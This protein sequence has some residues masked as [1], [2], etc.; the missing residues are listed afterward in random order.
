[1][2]GYVLVFKQILWSPTGLKPLLYLLLAFLF[3]LTLTTVLTDVKYVAFFGETQRRNGFFSY[4][5]LAIILLLTST[6]TRLFNVK[7]LFMATLVIA[8]VTSGYALMQTTGRDFINWI[9][10]HNSLIGTQGNPNFAAALMA[11]MG[12][13]LFSLAF[14]SQFKPYQRFFAVIV[15]LTL[16]VLIFRSN[17]RQGLL[18]YGLGVGMFLIIWL[19]ERRKNLGIAAMC[20]G[21]FLL[22][23]SILGMLQIGPLERFLYK[24][25]VSVR[26]F[27]WRAGLEMFKD[28]P[29]FG[30]GMDRYGAY[31]MQYREL[32]Y[33]LNYGFEITNNNAH[34]TFIQLFATGGFFLGASYILILGFIFKRGISALKVLKGNDQLLLAGLFSAWMA[35]HAQSF[36]SIDN[37]GIS[38]WGWVLG[39]AIVGLSVST[40]S[41]SLEDKKYFIIKHNTVNLKRVL[42]SSVFTIF[43]ICLVIILYRGENNAFKAAIDFDPQNQAS[44]NF[45]K[46]AQDEAANTPL[47]DLNYS[48][49][50]AQNLINA[51]FY[52]QGVTMLKKIHSYDPRNLDAITVLA[53]YYE[54]IS[55]IPEAILYREKIIQL[56]QWSAPTYLFLG[57]NYKSQGNFEK[58]EEMFKKLLSFATGVNGE[59]IAEQA[60]EE[61]LP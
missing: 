59:P 15:A 50:L 36:V 41:T 23:F 21:I 2:I 40:T 5:S 48:V 25:S 13:I 17:A 28:N 20:A 61:L 22:V 49:R 38:I 57:R 10:P 9:N 14:N 55:D 51:G 58:S 11:V 46:K 39:G 53:A 54:S 56:N 4:A 16:L 3:S 27:Y 1:L 29:L 7:K 19:F 42:T 47:L 44:I 35:F 34:N 31:F 6:V 30:V 18:S 45:F 43:A 26:G 60:R 52:E 12:V 24:P 33:P 37:P 8:V 32:G